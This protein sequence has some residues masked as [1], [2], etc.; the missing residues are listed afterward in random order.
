MK[1]I[2]L[3]GGNG[4]RLYPI[5]TATSKQ[6]VPIYD[7][8]MIYYPMSVLMLAGIREVLIISKPEDEVR[9][10]KLFGN[11]TD[12][13]MKIDF[14]VQLEPSGL[15]DAFM[16]GEDFIGGGCVSLILGD[17][18]FYGPNFSALLRN[19][20]SSI[21]STGGAHIFTYPVANPSAFGVLN[22][23]TDGKIVSIEEKPQNPSSKSAITGLYFYDKEVVEHA[24]SLSPSKR[25]ELEITDINNIYLERNKL[26]VTELG[27]GYT[28]LDTGTVENLLE[29]SMFVHTLEKRQGL[30]IACLEEISW[31]MGW[32]SEEQLQ[33]RASQLK[34]THYGKY[35]KQ[36]TEK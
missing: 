14:A 36:L 9:F 24:K 34:N 23:N 21:K 4:T 35:L 29:S 10:K 6:L 31:R 20:V 3:A 30:K 2:I 28:W 22:K 1:G 12:L 32:I 16:I 27:R 8:P 33:Y 26:A 25:G 15:P 7:K 17:N 18:L 11:G 13:G 5:T 19:T